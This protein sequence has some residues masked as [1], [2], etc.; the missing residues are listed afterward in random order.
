MKL[1]VLLLGVDLKLLCFFFVYNKGCFYEVYC[2]E[3]MVK[4]ND[5]VFVVKMED[6]YIF[7]REM[8]F[9][10]MI[11]DLVCVMVLYVDFF[12]VDLIFVNQNGL[13]VK[14]NY[15]FVNNLE[16][17]LRMGDF[18]EVVIIVEKFCGKIVLEF[19][20]EQFKCLYFDGGS[21]ID[22]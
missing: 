20:W 21:L 1:C 2:C 7:V 17:K 14:V 6:E 4:E 11:G 13:C 16:Q 22:D 19:Q 3:L 12:V 9:G 15:E 8:F 18:V 5:L 10:F